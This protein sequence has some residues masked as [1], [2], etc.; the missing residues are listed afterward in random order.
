[1]ASKKIRAI[2]AVALLVVI[3]GYF[4]KKYF[5]APKLSTAD[6]TISTFLGEKSTLDQYKGKVIV[7][8]VW[9]T[10]CPPCVQEMPMLDNLFVEYEN[11][12]VLF[13]L[14]SDEE[15]PKLVNFTR[16]KALR[17][18]LYHL[19][20]NMNDIGVYTIPA[21]FVFDKKGKLIH[22]KLGIFESAEELKA[23]ID[24]LL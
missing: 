7:F 13:I 2:I 11:K 4:A 22:S 19:P 23:L 9:A 21:T 18:P 3:A 20:Y 1:M 8:N 24:P 15:I 14:A 17:V 6:I 10:W 16:Q 12:E 5:I